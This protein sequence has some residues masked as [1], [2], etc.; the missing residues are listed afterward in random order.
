M[1]TLINHQLTII[2]FAIL[3]LFLIY[4]NCVLEKRSVIRRLYLSA[5]L[6]NLFLTLSNLLLKILLE[7]GTI[8]LMLLRILRGINFIVSPILAYTFLLFVCNYFANPFRIKK[9]AGLVFN[10]LFFANTITA[11][12]VFKTDMFINK[13]GTG[14]YILPFSISLILLSYSIFVIFK[15]R[16]L[17]LKVEYIYIMSV[18]LMIVAVTAFQ[19]I[20]N[21]TGYIWCFNSLILILMFVIIQQG[22]LYKDSLTGARNRQALQKCLDC[23]EKRNL[24]RLSAVMIDLDYFKSIND[25]Y[26]H[27]EGDFALKAFVKMLQ[28]VYL[29]SGIVFR[30]GGD[31]FLVLIDNRSEPQIHDLM[32]KV[33]GVVE[34]F[35]AGGNKP[36][37]IK[38]S[39]AFGTYKRT[40]KGVNQFLH[41][42]DLQMYNNKNGKKRIFGEGLQSGIYA[43]IL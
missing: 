34:K 13:L 2:S 40:D 18:S 3:L 27:S 11:I 15:R 43:G 20:L 24:S 29:N 37:S 38:Y 26:G 23:Y 7:S 4:A 31:E 42:I 17:L 8:P 12:I 39:Y 16:K 9:Q 41:E 1:Q 10:L 35:N 32:K 22:E 14:A 25:L 19:L 30:T 36:Y 21:K 28:R 5:V 6:L 33:S